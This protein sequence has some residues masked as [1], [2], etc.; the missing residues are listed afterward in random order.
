M[1]EFV[2]RLEL[3]FSSYHSAY[4]DDPEDNS[5]LQILVYF[6]REALDTIACLFQFHLLFA[7]ASS[8]GSVL[9]MM[10]TTLEIFHSDSLGLDSKHHATYRMLM[11]TIPSLYSK[12]YITSVENRLAMETT[13]MSHFDEMIFEVQK[14]SVLEGVFC[15]ASFLNSLIQMPPSPEILSLTEQVSQQMFRLFTVDQLS[16]FET[17]EELSIIIR[18]M[19]LIMG[20]KSDYPPISFVREALVLFMNRQLP[21]LMMERGVMGDLD[22][23]IMMYNSKFLYDKNGRSLPLSQSPLLRRMMLCVVG[24]LGDNPLV[25]LELVSNMKLFHQ[26]ILNLGFHSLILPKR[27][28]ASLIKVSETMTETCRILEGSKHYNSISSELICFEV[29]MLNLV[30]GPN[31]NSFPE[32][33]VIEITNK[34]SLHLPNLTSVKVMSR[35]QVSIMQILNKLESLIRGKMF[36]TRHNL[37]TAFR[38]FVLSNLSFFLRLMANQSFMMFARLMPLIS[39]IISD[40]KKSSDLSCMRDFLSC[41]KGSF[42][43][44]LECVI[45][46]PTLS[47]GLEDTLSNDFNATLR[48]LIKDF[49]LITELEPV[50]DAS[51]FLKIV[52]NQMSLLKMNYYFLVSDLNS[53]TQVTRYLVLRKVLQAV[54]KFY[55]GQGSRLIQKMGMSSSPKM[56]FVGVA[57]L[58]QMLKATNSPD[59]RLKYYQENLASYVRDSEISSELTMFCEEVLEE[60]V[61]EKLVQRRL[62][63]KKRDYS[64]IESKQ[65]LKKSFDIT[66]GSLEVHDFFTFEAKNLFVNP[67]PRNIEKLFSL[68]G[69]GSLLPREE[70]ESKIEDFGRRQERGFFKTVSSPDPSFLIK[71]VLEQQRNLSEIMRD[72]K[73]EL[74]LFMNRGDLIQSEIKFMF[75]SWLSSEELSLET[76]AGVVEYAALCLDVVS[77]GDIETHIETLMLSEYRN[78][79]ESDHA[80]LLNLL[81]FI[82]NMGTT[83]VKSKV[84]ISFMFSFAEI[85]FSMTSAV[86]PMSGKLRLMRALLCVSPKF[87]SIRPYL[88]SLHEDFLEFAS[89]PC[90]PESYERCFLDYEQILRYIRSAYLPPGENL[91]RIISQLRGQRGH[92]FHPVN[93]PSLN[94]F[95]SQLYKSQQTRLILILDII[96]LQKREVPEL[97]VWVKKNVSVCGLSLDLIVED[98]L[99]LQLVSPLDTVHSEEVSNEHLFRKRVLA[100]MNL[101]YA[102][103]LEHDLYAMSNEQM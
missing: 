74:S 98:R 49:K 96:R 3:I 8:L 92:L 5:R 91:S 24:S 23:M 101:Y 26:M 65:N 13:V 7:S 43:V 45:M 57:Q 85:F 76:K 82:C 63:K 1:A 71:E 84:I 78:I 59:G 62:S 51:R 36:A 16:D 37:M 88:R 35:I 4:L 17:R 47:S 10:K 72:D 15:L 55:I 18:T 58:F 39:W 86:L 61:E 27:S 90:S 19:S 31:V 53:H 103:I 38:N 70:I 83:R 81:D 11:N 66:S 67:S 30:L 68:E 28:V 50:K 97:D 75:E 9:G 25:Q 46:L 48:R 93:H 22:A 99:V 79:F 95:C 44:S 56:V 94:I 87:E 42:N 12:M 14:V 69:A 60:R 64:E 20:I 2:F 32:E 73:G 33:F 89:E 54:L 40:V 34:L 80:N 102:T 41:D 100:D 77:F 21:V 52:Q 29:S 6:T